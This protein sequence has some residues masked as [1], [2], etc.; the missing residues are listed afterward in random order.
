[1]LHNKITFLKKGTKKR[2]DL[3]YALKDLRKRNLAQNINIFVLI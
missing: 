1:M 2:Q 3:L